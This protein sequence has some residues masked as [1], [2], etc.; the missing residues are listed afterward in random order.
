MSAGGADGTVQ[1]LRVRL[2]GPR[3][4]S[5]RVVGVGVLA[6]APGVT[7]EEGLEPDVEF[8][9]TAMYVAFA[10]TLFTVLYGL[11]PWFLN[12][13]LLMAQG[14]VDKLLG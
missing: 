3:G 6:R 9:S 2:A 10:T 5:L 13:I 4:A 11:H 8:D 1:A 14:A 12:P 7:P